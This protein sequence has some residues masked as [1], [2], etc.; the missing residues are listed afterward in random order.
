MERQWAKRQK[1]IDRVVR[2][3]AGMYGD[4]QG[5]IATL[6]DIEVLELSASADTLAIEDQ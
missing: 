3:M 4:M 6:P 2:N 1:Q 5:I